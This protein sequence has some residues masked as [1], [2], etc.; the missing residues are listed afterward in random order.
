MKI[1]NYI[2]CIFLALV[3]LVSCEHSGK[4]SQSVI[5]LPSADRID[6]TVD[7]VT[8]NVFY[9]EEDVT[10]EARIFMSPDNK[11]LMENTLK[12]T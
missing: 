2:L 6:A 7:S 1:T 5:L 8:F 3:I 9:G 11:E 4:V 12:D 10:G